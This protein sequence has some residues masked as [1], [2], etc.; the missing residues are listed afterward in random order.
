MRRRINDEFA[1]LPISRQRKYQ[2]RMRRAGRC[3][4]CGEPAVQGSRC[5]KHLV[6]ARERQRR[7]RGLKRRY[8]GTLSYRLQS[9]ARQKRL[10]GAGLSSPVRSEPAR[11]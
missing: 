10:A 8:R 2:L 4:E 3:A 6:K 9:E 11:L 1:D 5:L 7:K